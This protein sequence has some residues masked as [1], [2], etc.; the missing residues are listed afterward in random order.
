MT[1]YN[2]NLAKREQVQMPEL[3]DIETG[4]EIERFTSYN[5]DLSFKG[6]TYKAAPIQRSQMKYDSNLGVQNVEI[7]AATSEQFRSHIASV[8][9]NPTRI[10]IWRAVS[11]DL[12]EYAK[13][14]RGQVLRVA[15]REMNT[16]ASCIGKNAILDSV[17]PRVIYQ[18]TCNHMLFD[19][20]CKLEQSVY[21]VEAEISSISGADYSANILGTYDDYYF[22]HGWAVYGNSMRL[23]TCHEGTVITLQ[24]QFES[25]VDIGSIIKVYPGCNG[26]YST[27][28]GKFANQENF[29][30]MTTIPSKN[31]CIWGFK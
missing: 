14:F 8:P 19:D 7:T 1:T 18:S 31:P 15:A 29:L 27:C 25:I 28:A 24:L 16:T 6:Y 22:D 21:K 17:F 10:T 11:D 20:Q 4:D 26:H 2:D 3:Y 5:I 9:I 30:G 13:I 23:I 12:T